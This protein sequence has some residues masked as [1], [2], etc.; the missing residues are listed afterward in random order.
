[1]NVNYGLLTELE[2]LQLNKGAAEIHMMA[3]AEAMWDARNES[4]P[5]KLRVGEWHIPFEGEVNLQQLDNCMSSE[6]G[7]FTGDALTDMKI[8]VSTVMAARTSYTVV[9]DDLKPMSYEKML[10]LDAK[11]IHADP[12]HAS[13]LEHCA[14]TMTGFERYWGNDGWCRNFQGF[15]QRRALIEQARTR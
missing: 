8:Q 11:L 3:L 10:E 2:W 6:H 4:E 7:K 14:R 15:I 9:G 1:M 5:K 12:L 13:P